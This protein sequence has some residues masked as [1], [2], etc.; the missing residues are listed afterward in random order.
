MTEAAAA[1]EKPQK[2]NH[3]LNASALA[4]FVPATYNVFLLQQTKLFPTSPP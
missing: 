2:E 1:H 4:Q 3:S